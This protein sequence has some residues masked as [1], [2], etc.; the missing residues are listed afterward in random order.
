[1]VSSKLNPINKKLMY[2][3]QGYVEA[4]QH[5]VQGDEPE[6]HIQQVIHAFDDYRILTAVRHGQ[7]GLQQLEPLR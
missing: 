6:P 1:M 4:L 5:Y 7:L 2:G 3:F